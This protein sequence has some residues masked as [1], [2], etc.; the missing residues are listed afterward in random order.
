MKLITF[1]WQYPNSWKNLKV[2]LALLDNNSKRLQNKI[3][4]EDID[5]IEGQNIISSAVPARYILKYLQVL[6]INIQLL[7]RILT[8]IGAQQ[9]YKT[10][11]KLSKQ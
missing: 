4:M 10:F 6:F 7:A 9:L 3:K 5:R 11:E 1:F 2:S 8:E